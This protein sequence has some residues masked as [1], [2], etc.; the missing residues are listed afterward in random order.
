MKNK[1]LNR[2]MSS[3]QFSP[4]Y[5]KIFQ[6]RKMFLTLVTKFENPV[7]STYKVTGG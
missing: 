4:K 6:T 3:E 7:R 1:K 5:Y 2:T